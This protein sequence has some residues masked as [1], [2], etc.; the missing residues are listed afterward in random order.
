[1]KLGSKTFLY[2]VIIALIIG[3][4]KSHRKGCA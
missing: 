4:R 1:M 3:A 2:S